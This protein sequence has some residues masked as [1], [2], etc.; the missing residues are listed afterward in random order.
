MDTCILSEYKADKFRK[1]CCFASLFLH[2]IITYTLLTLLGMGWDRK[3]IPWSGLEISMPLD[4]F[5]DLSRGE[6]FERTHET[7]ILRLIKI[8]NI[9][10]N[11]I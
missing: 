1:F 11:I 4:A 10:W 2:Y 5:I 7:I 8:I 3:C 6:S 9:N